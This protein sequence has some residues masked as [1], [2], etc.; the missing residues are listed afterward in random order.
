MSAAAITNYG[1]ASIYVGEREAATNTRRTLIKFD[2]SS[3]PTNAVISSATLTLNLLTD[4][5]ANARTYR[6]YRLKR[7]WVE[8]EATWNIWS[9]GNNWSTAGGFHADDC[10]Q[11]E[12]GSRVMS[13]TEAAGLKDFTITATTKAELDLGNGWMIKADTEI[14]DCYIFDSREGGT[15]PKLVIVYTSY[16]NMTGTIEAQS[17]LEGTFYSAGIQDM[18]GTIP[19][20]SVLT[21][22]LSR[23][24]LLQ[25][26]IPTQSRIT[27]ALT[28]GTTVYDI[29]ETEALQV[30]IGGIN[31]TPYMT[32]DGEGFSFENALTNRMDTAT[33]TLAATTP[34]ERM[35]VLKVIPW[36]E[37]IV[38]RVTDGAVRFAGYIVSRRL[39]PFLGAQQAL[40]S[41]LTCQDY[42]CLL[43]R[44]HVNVTFSDKTDAVIINS[45]ITTYA[46]TFNG[47][48]YVST[49]K[50]LETITFNRVSIF[51]ALQQ[52]CA[53]TGYDW[54]V[55]DDKNIHYFTGEANAAP[56]PLSDS[57]T[58]SAAKYATFSYDDDA[59]QVKNRVYVYGG[60]YLSDTQTE[61]FTGN[62][63]QTIWKLA[64]PPDSLPVITVDGAAMLEGIDG[65]DDSYTHDVLCN[66]TIGSI[67]FSTNT[68]NGDRTPGA[69]A[70]IVVTYQYRLPVLIRVRREA[71]HTL[72]GVWLD[73][74]VIDRNITSVAEA[75]VAGT[76][77][78]NDDAFSR[79][80]INITTL[81]GGF[82][83][84]QVAWVINGTVG[85]DGYYLIKRVSARCISAVD[86]T[87]MYTLD[88]GDWHGN[89]VDLLKAW[90]AAHA[91]AMDVR[92]DEQLNEYLDQ[93][94]DI[95][96]TAD[97]AIIA[98][99]T[100][101]LWD[102][103]N[104]NAGTWS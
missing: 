18:S 66:N 48:T 77:L 54:Y 15:T 90:Q 7:A 86:W 38:S 26:T 44:T 73:Y 46:P 51:D 75:S 88:L 22:L 30:T 6:I 104:W 85:I 36:Q 2:L 79:E 60:T 97:V 101:S 65:T 64:Y 95:T 1:T 96:L 17:V 12:I 71:S 9:T 61:T 68:T 33:I 69:T 53:V 31:Y 50:T 89:V 40:Y 11:T 4:Q 16:Q 10:E 67:R 78:L 80:T 45:L 91:P 28:G 34:D 43:Q 20:Q 39:L 81:V 102:S 58:T 93:T 57:G 47:T 83:S 5:S 98:E 24:A 27:A 3:L 35:E 94:E 42:S 100:S 23:D 76:S 8:L 103:F 14:D 32:I 63:S 29:P 70:Q 56:F 21:G 82:R 84:G 99:G 92:D 87:M 74:K 55:D 59:S 37:V 52:I 25:G 19:A 62:A 72:Y 13:A 41:V 49:G